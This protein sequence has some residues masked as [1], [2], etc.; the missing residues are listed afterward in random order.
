MTVSYVGTPFRGWQ[1]QRQGDTIQERLETAL[2]RI[3]SC[4]TRVTGAGRTDAGVHARGQVAHFQATM[5]RPVE[6]L[7]G[8]LNSLL[9]Q[10]IRVERLSRARP[11]FHARKDARGKHYR[12]QL[13]TVKKA[14]PFLAPYVS[15]CPGAVPEVERMLKGAAVLLGHH[16]F[17]AFCG[18]GSAVKT[19]GRTI[20]RLDLRRRGDTILF[21]VE[22]DG[23]LRHQVRNIVG[24]LI[25]LG[26]G[27]RTPASLRALLRS[28]DRRQAGA[29]APAA[30]LCLMKVHYGPQREG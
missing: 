21:D 12:Y 16:D 13:L 6:L 23:F 4:P 10:E 30:G 3:L 26:Q 8:A 14:S 18:A 9:P 27:K 28:R 19:T 29:T 2:S 24:T 7:R 17:A 1:V 20:T 15:R 5:G 11:G 25:E 22:G